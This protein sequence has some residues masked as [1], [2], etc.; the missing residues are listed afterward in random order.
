MM[1]NY[2]R[3][4][5]EV[6]A[7]CGRVLEELKQRGELDRTLVIFTGDNGYSMPNTVWP[8]NGI[9][10]RKAFGVPL[11]V[12]DPR[13]AKAKQGA[14]MTS[15]CSTWIWPCHSF[16]RRD[17][18]AAA[19]AGDGFCAALPGRPAARVATEFF[20]EHATIRNTNFIPASESLV[21]KDWKYFHWPDFKREQ[22]LISG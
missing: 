8:T 16:R 17:C 9:R 19:D 3:L 5:T 18:R 6:D 20:E 2:Y 13:L 4:V 1:K 10:T 22:L 11:I 21:R 12:R 7:T 15:S 14:P